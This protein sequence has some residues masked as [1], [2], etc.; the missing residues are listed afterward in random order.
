MSSAVKQEARIKGVCAVLFPSLV[1]LHYDTAFSDMITVFIAR[2]AIQRMAAW[3]YSVFLIVPISNSCMPL[4]P[5]P[6][7]PRGQHT[8]DGQQ[9]EKQWVIL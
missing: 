2:G 6:L 5:P 1:S 3:A 9:S 7:P 8:W 4:Q